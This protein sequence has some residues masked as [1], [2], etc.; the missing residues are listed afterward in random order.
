MK[1][2]YD[3]NIKKINQE[4]LEKENQNIELEMKIKQTQLSGY[5]DNKSFD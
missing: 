1:E 4:K 2:E 5:S 3:E